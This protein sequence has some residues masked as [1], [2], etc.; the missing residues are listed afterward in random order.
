MY[1]KGIEV[2]LKDGQ[3]YKIGK[4]EDDCMLVQRQAASAYASIAELYMTDLCDEPNAE[5]SCEQ[6]LQEALKVAAQNVD[7]L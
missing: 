3:S 2:L 1:K 6:A 4:R 7:A 5:Q